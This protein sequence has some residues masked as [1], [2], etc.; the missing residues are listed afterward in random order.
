MTRKIAILGTGANGSSIAA[1]L[2]RAGRD[3]ILIDQWPAHV[4]KMKADGLVINM[5]EESL[6]VDVRAGH[7]CDL[8][9]WN[10]TFDVVFLVVK[11]FDTR[12]MAE[13][14]KP[15]L[16]EDGL[17]IGIQ[18]GMT[19]ETI[20]E[21]V[22]PHRTLGCA[23]ELSSEIFDPGIVKRNTPPSRTWIGIGALEPSMEVRLAEIRDILADVGSVELVADILSTKWMKLIINTM[24]MGLKGLANM[25]TGE[26]LAVPGMREIMLRAGEEALTIGQHLG[27]KTAPI[28]GL[29]AAEVAGTNRL[30]ELMLNQTTAHVGLGNRVAVLQDHI[31]GRYSEVDQINGFRRRRE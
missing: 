8:C 10:E 24:S 30:C 19:A 31:K 12:W 25:T 28:V 11:A 17:L 29:S 13:F 4:E 5:P 27:Y 26:I 9:S 16:A 23:I 6:H 18:N 20:A 14:I 21:I 15:Y 2:T 22:E 3:P 7:M 1:D